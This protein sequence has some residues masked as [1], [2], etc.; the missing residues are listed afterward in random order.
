[1]ASLR[2]KVLLWVDLPALWVREQ[3]MQWLGVGDSLYVRL[4]L[5]AKGSDFHAQST[6][7]WAPPTLS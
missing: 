2:R 1:M 7:N 6:L 5:A 4:Y 3:G